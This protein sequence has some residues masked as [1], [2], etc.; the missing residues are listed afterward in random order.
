MGQGQSSQQGGAAPQRGDE[1]VEKRD[2]YV[3][4]GV[5]RTA[6]DDE[7]KKAYRR[8]ALE[9][10]PDR[11]YGDVERT[12][13]LFAEVQAAYEVL[14]DPQERAWYDSHRDQI[15]YG[16][17]GGDHGGGDGD[18]AAPYFHNMKMTTADELDRV[19]LQFNPKMAFSDSPEG[20]FGGL[21]E[22]FDRLAREEEVASQWDPQNPAPPI[23]YPSFGSRDDGADVV[24]PFYAAWSS[25]AT[26][27][28][29]AWRDRYKLSEAPDRR[30]RRLMEKENRKR[31]DDG[32]RQFND[33]VRALVAFVRK[34]DPR[35]K[36]TAQSEEER[37]RALRDA[38]AAQAARSRAAN[39]RL[40]Q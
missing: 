8:K 9:L 12:T 17:H 31:R 11:N 22:L 27:K 37:R 32:A 15:L 1:E 3:L 34:R 39:A 14:S 2:Y 30:V 35:V 13:T 23:D 26:R 38:A 21:R 24:R 4:L 33:A 20:F 6:T 40:A 19:V 10:H 18:G 29:F 28:S 25:F 36:A 7:I 16:D 5:E